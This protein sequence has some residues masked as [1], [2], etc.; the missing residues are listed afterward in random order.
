MSALAAMLD[1]LEEPREETPLFPVQPPDGRKDWAEGPRQTVFFS[2]LR[3]AAPSLNAWHTPNEGKRNPMKA[4]ASGIVGGVFDVSVASTN[5]RPRRADLEL[6]GYDA[7]GRAGSLSEAQIRWGNR[8]YRAGHPV[9]CFFCPDAA[10]AW[11]R[12]VFPEA[13]S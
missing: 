6:K 12:G 10:I 8:M 3:M 5:G 11:L 13:F 9:A 1:A 4:L 2:R 7:R